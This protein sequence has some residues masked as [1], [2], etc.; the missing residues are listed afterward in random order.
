MGIF[1][2]LFGAK[3][4]DGQRKSVPRAQKVAIEKRFTL[5][6][7]I[8]QGSMSKVWKATD[9]FSGRSVCL[10]VL[11]KD[12]TAL[13]KR[14]FIG[15]NRPD[16]G[17]V[18]MMLDHPNVVKTFETGT[19]IFDEEYLVMELIEGVGL[20]FLIDTKSPKLVGNEARILIEAAEGLHHFHE[21]GFIHRD[22]CPRNIMMTHE[23]VV[24]LIDFGLA[25]PNTAEFRRP[26]N[27]TG[28]ANYMAPELIK[29]RT[30]DQRID[31]YSMGVT[32]FE[33]FTGHHPW[34]EES[35]SMQSML[36]HIN[37]PGRKP[38]DL[39]P[40][41]DAEVYRILIKAIDRDPDRRYQTA[42]A[43]IGDL[44]RYTGEEEA[45]EP[46]EAKVTAR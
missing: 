7:R 28:S 44:K 21:K 5:H 41:L 19:T 14:R 40:G 10:K 43:F 33:T 20:N 18:A 31:L 4:R 24:K 17:E 1:S 32:A 38:Q 22:I 16:E 46:V 39:K 3:K 35:Q 36:K 9:N 27:R 2:K 12:K 15:M 26:G 11:D 37:N 34:E 29:R 6:N 45:E 30:T 13:L 8:G 25:V 23:G 42:R